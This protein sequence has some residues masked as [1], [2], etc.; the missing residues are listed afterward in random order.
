MLL[1]KTQ[2]MLAHPVVVARL[3]GMLLVLIM[4]IRDSSNYKIRTHAA[5]AL[6]SLRTRDMFGD[7]FPS[8]VQVCAVSALSIVVCLHVKAKQVSFRFDT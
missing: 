6:M 3:Q 2:S 5:A 7:C 4:L 8:A 1:S